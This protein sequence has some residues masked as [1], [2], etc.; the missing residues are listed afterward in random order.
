MD[1]GILLNSFALSGRLNKV[2]ILVLMDDGILR[3]ITAIC[4]GGE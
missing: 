1:D 2:S 3:N 4:L